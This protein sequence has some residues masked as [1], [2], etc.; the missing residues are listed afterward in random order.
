MAKNGFRAVKKKKIMHVQRR[1]KYND[2]TTR[3]RR[4]IVNICII[5]TSTG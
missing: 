3:E 4:H 1:Q 5:K 2:V